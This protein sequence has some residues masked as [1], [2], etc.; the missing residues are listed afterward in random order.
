MSNH[1]YAVAESF[2]LSGAATHVQLL[3]RAYVLWRT[4]DRSVCAAPDRC[5]HREAPLS[6]GSVADGVLTC[7]YHGWSFGDAGRCVA[8][9]SADPANPVPPAAHLR[10][11][12]AEER[13][14]LVW[15]CPG[16]PAGSVP[17][18]PHDTD[19]AFRRINTGMEVWDV[20]STRMTDNF[21]D[22]SHFPWVHAGTFGGGQTAR[23]P[24]IELQDLDDDFFGYAYE[25]DANNPDEA[26]ITSSSDAQ[27]VH[28]WMTTG[29]HLPFTVRSTVRYE[30]GLEH[31]ILL[32]STPIDDEHSY[33]SFVIWR[34]DDFSVDAQGVISFDR[35][36]GAEDKLMLERVPGVLPLDR[37][38]VVSVQADKASVEWRRQLIELLEN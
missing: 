4:P 13:Y 16:T 33:F 35:S 30:T 8:V 12:H 28:R 22:I 34:N 31:I 24:L 25:V 15:I 38:G 32:I 36:I 2:D 5:P 37:T 10:C 19:P 11:V 23:V 21:L 27:T 7:A 18:V 1:W 17:A 20:S 9:P 29:F 14:G 26:R 6:L 3:G